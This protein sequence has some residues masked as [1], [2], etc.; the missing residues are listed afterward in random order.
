PIARAMG[1]KGV[2]AIDIDPDKRAAALAG[3][4]LAAVDPRVPEAL[5]LVQAAVGGAPAC[6]IDFVGSPM[7]SELGFNLLAKGGRLV[8][9]GLFGGAATFPLAMIAVRGI[10]I[11]GNLV[12]NLADMTELMALVSAGKVASI[13]ILKRPLD[14]ADAALSALRQ[15]H[16][17]GRTVLIP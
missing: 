1:A 16:V 5:A 15:G 13:P 17:V 9:V 12:G 2:V 3:G 14:E 11:A 10:T 6:V 7:T 8:M 4:A